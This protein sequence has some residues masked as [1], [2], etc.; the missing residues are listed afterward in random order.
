MKQTFHIIAIKN[1][2]D[3]PFLLI[4]ILREKKALLFDAGY[5]YGVDTGHLLK[6]SDIFITH[7]HIDHFIGFDTILRLLLRRNSPLKVFGPKGI[8][9]CIEGKLKGYTWNLIKDYPIKIEAYEVYRNRINHSSFYAQNSFKRV[10]ND[11]YEFNKTI[12]VDP[13]YKVDALE[14]SH[15][16]PV[17]SFSINEDF[18]I[19]INKEALLE[20]GLPIGPWLSDFKKALKR[21][22]NL[23]TKQ[24]IDNEVI[25][26]VNNSLYTLKDLMPIAVIT[27]GQKISYV[28]DVSPTEENFS[29]LIPFI[30]HSDHL[31]C[32]AYF[33]EKDR[34]RA[35]D[36]HHLTA[37]DAG[38]LAKE[39]EVLNLTLMHFSP[40]Y[41]N[42]PQ[43]IYNEAMDAFKK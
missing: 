12:L 10:D 39:A 15:Q 29:K 18:H 32:E 4:R 38:R 41:I 30:K 21:Y 31:F 42:S 34:Q 6:I 7:T 27:K 25:L 26:K 17:L 13:L 3:D 9:D 16:I 37:S 19:N 14:L 43:E 1:P 8:I 33:L 2:F 20:L 28:M 11:S 24:L 5:I 40:K 22:Y 36:R 23:E 35:I